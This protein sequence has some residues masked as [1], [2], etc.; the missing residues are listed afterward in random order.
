[1][2]LNDKLTKAK[3]H[4]PHPTPHTH[5]HPLCVRSLGWGRE[6]VPVLW[7]LQHPSSWRGRQDAGKADTSQGA[8]TITI[9][10]S[11]QGKCKYCGKMLEWNEGEMAG[12]LKMESRHHFLLKVM[13]LARV[14]PKVFSYASALSRNPSWKGGM[15]TWRRTPRCGAGGEERLR[16]SPWFWT[17]R[18]TINPWGDFFLLKLL[19]L[20]M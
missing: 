6:C 8:C 13:K 19:L 18:I 16:L 2:C 7:T 15:E 12:V 10:C 3:L 17:P 4:S 9:F 11:L 20:M 5:T 14:M 1:M